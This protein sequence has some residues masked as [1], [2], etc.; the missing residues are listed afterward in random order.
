[1]GITKAKL[2]EIEGK[3]VKLPGHLP[4]SEVYWLVERGARTMI[5]DIDHMMEVGIRSPIHTLDE[6]ELLAIP[7]IEEAT[8]EPL[9]EGD[10]LEQEE[11]VEGG[12]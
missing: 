8:N 5:R 9:V 10:V 2:K 4:L 7:V 11:T 6:D 1:M 3:F 12:G